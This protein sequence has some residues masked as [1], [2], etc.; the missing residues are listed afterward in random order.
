MCILIHSQTERGNFSGSRNQSIV[1]NYNLIK[2]HQE[3]FYIQ[4]VYYY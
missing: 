4:K 3:K 1:N 2:I